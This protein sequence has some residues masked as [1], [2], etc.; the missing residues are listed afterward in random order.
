[1]SQAIG[2]KKVILTAI[3]GID[4]F[5]ISNMMPPEGRFNIKY[6]LTRVMDLLLAEIFPEGTKRHA[7]RVNIHLRIL[8]GR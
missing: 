2:T 6:F 7:V 3:W 1:V 5:H 8:L 4:E